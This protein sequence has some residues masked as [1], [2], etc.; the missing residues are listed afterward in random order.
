MKHIDQKSLKEIFS[1]P[2]HKTSVQVIS[3]RGERGNRFDWK[4]DLTGNQK[5]LNLVSDCPF[6]T[7]EEAMKVGHKVAGVLK[8]KIAD[9][10]VR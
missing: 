8:A 9:G 2:N 10:S 3:R 4:I 5:H 7:Y 6:P 1:D